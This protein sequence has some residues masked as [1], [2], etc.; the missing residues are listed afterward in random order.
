MSILIQ[1]VT[2]HGK[3][4]SWWL[5]LDPFKKIELLITMVGQDQG[6]SPKDVRRMQGMIHKSY[7]N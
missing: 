4:V 1:A 6:L 7:F 2:T 3:S 5:A